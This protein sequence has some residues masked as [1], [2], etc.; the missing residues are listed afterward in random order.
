MINTWELPIAIQ[1][2]RGV[3]M[4][5]K[6]IAGILIV[7]SA[8]LLGVSIAGIVLVW[9]YKQPL[10][11]NATSWLQTVDREL[12]QAHTA[13][14]DAR[15]ELERTL[16]L[17]EAAETGLAALKQEFAQVKTLFD[18]TTGFLDVQLLPGLK[19]SREKIDQAK[20]T[21][22]GLRDTLAQINSLGLL[23]LTIPGDE[24]LADLIGSADSLNAQITGVEDVVKNA[25]TFVS[26]AAYLMGSDFTDTKTSLQNFLVIV[27]DYD[28]KLTGWRSQVAGL[29]ASLPG[30]IL[31]TC[32]GLTL[33]LLWFGFS[34]VIL[35]LNGWTLWRRGDLPS[36]TARSGIQP[37]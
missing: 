10:T 22:Q 36:G 24:L 5:R 14:L 11:E 13:V 35:I 33:F 2:G 16:R 12:E 1:P 23:D 15:F 31:N 19:S 6:I 25:S 29:L 32:I 3:H 30:W 17:V 4:G 18:D 26:D 7:V 34:Q 37:K 8:I 9:T 21:L 20:A 27:T 28:Q